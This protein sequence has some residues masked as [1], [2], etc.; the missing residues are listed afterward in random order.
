MGDKVI[1]VL[2]GAYDIWSFENTPEGEKSVLT[3]M[4]GIFDMFACPAFGFWTSSFT[5]TYRM[6][7]GL[8]RGS[9]PKARHIICIDDTEGF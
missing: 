7:E 9:C 4:K 8:F 2:S 5:A 3:F 6:K 1:L